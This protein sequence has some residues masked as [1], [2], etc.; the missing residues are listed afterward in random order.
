M[1]NLPRRIWR[2]PLVFSALCLSCLAP[3]L[4]FA[5]ESFAP[6]PQPALDRAHCDALG[7][8]YLAVSGS[9]ACIKISGY[10]SAGTD[11]R[12]VV[13][14]GPPGAGPFAPKS[15]AGVETQ[16]AVSADTQFETPLGPAR[17]YV[18][19]GHNAYGQ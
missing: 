6:A 1:A 9:N 19:V 18:E 13:V 3:G 12:A 10:V 7:E 8:G 14:K 2:S 15:G 4:G 11:F 17:L 5:G 16:S